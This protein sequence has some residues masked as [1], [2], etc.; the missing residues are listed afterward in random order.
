ME[1]RLDGKYIVPGWIV[2]KNCNERI[3]EH[4]A[5]N[6]DSADNAET[7]EDEGEPSLFDL[8]MHQSDQ[9]ALLNDTLEMVGISTLKTHAL[10]KSSKVKD[11]CERVNRSFQRQKEIVK[12]IFEL[13]DTSEF[14]FDKPH[15]TPLDWPRKDVSSFFEVSELPGSRSSEIGS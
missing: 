4:I 12:D 1:F 5:I 13:P 9:R 10:A 14:N 2:C 7:T 8:T 11:A 3:K 6:Q 15:V